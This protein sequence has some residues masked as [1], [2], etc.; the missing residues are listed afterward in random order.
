MNKFLVSLALLLFASP[1][2]AQK[3]KVDYDKAADFSKF[4]TYSWTRGIPAKNPLVNLM[5]VEGIEQGMSSKGLTKV[6]TDGDLQLSLSV[7]VEFDLQVSHGGWDSRGN[8]GSS[9]QTGIPAGGSSTAWDVRKGTI[10][11]DMSDKTSKNLLWHGLASETI[12]AEPTNDFNKDA[13][14]VEKQVKRAIEKLFQK[15]PPSKN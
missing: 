5:L 8:T 11:L 6:E 13:K 14:K 15:F 1:V 12:K 4:K 2:L 3:V 10:V 7:A 9:L